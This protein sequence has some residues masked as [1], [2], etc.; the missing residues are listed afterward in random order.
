MKE[1]SQENKLKG[2]RKAA[3]TAVLAVSLAACGSNATE[4]PRP[5]ITPTEKPTPTITLA[6]TPEVTP[7]PTI[8]PEPTP[9]PTPEATLI[10]VASIIEGEHIKPSV[11][12]VAA[13]IQA[14]LDSNPQVLVD[15]WT[16]EKLLN[17]WKFCQKGDP[18]MGGDPNTNKQL[19]CQNLIVKFYQDYKAE[20]DQAFYNV[21]KD[22]YDYA[23]TTL[24]KDYVNNL[25]SNLE[26]FFN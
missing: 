5:T 14:V 11:S 20:K 2:F 12:N 18:E 25:N 23:A 1:R 26:Q 6:P 7:T 17:F 9:T 21:A 8:T 13:E 24:P 15:G 3:G 19:N 10:P 4:T 16:T 22:V